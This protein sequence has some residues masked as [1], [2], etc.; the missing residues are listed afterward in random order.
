M[1]N[2][3]LPADTTNSSAYIASATYIKADVAPTLEWYS[4]APYVATAISTT[5][6]TGTVTTSV[7]SFRYGGPDK[8]TAKSC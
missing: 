5:S 3:Y 7:R 8:A 4:Y 6:S 2:G 1:G